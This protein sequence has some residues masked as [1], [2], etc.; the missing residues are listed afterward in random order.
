M[1]PGRGLGLA[2]CDKMSKQQS[3][4]RFLGGKRTLSDSAD[5]R[6]LRREK[7]RKKL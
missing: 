7:S 6:R 2:H 5:E 4:F 3:L 1:F